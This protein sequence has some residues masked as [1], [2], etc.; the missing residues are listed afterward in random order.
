M[1][2]FALGFIVL[3]IL[4]TPAFAKDCD[5]LNGSF[6]C[7]DGT[8]YLI[9]GEAA[10]TESPS[11]LA[12]FAR[13]APASAPSYQSAQPVSQ[14]PGTQDCFSL[15]SENL[16]CAPRNQL[17]PGMALQNGV[18]RTR[19][20]MGSDGSYG[21]EVA[22]YVAGP[23]YGQWVIASQYYPP[24][25]ESAA[26]RQDCGFLHLGC[27]HIEAGTLLT[28]RCR[29]S[30]SSWSYRSGGHKYAGRRSSYSCY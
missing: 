29:D 10:P 16:G 30:G 13:P 19:T 3:S 27:V 21:R 22:T 1:K 23:M 14:K 17:P 12:D 8:S 25:A 9:R 6:V 5:E 20:T 15:G 26:P 2:T 28:G 4:T 11:T 24:T 7:A 18:V